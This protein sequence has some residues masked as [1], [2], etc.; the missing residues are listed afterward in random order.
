MSRAGFYEQIAANRQDSE[1]LQA[2]IRRT[3]DHFRGD[4]TSPSRPGVLLGKVQSGKTRAFLGIIALA[5]DEGYDAAVILT[6][7]T[8]SLAR[9]TIQRVKADFASFIADD[10]VQ[11]Y[12]I[13][14]LVELTGYELSQK[15]IFV[16]KK[17][18]DNMGRLLAAFDKPE[19]RSKRLL[20][21][22]DEADFASVT[23]RQ[24]G[25]VPGPGV[26]ASRIDKLQKTVADS[27][28]LQVTATPYSL[29]L[30]P[31][32]SA[33]RHGESLFLPKKPSFTEI[34]PIHSG[35]VGG[36]AYF[37]NSSDPGSTAHY[38]YREVPMQER[39]ALKKPDGRR[40]RLDQVLTHNNAAVLRQA[41]MT[42]LVGGVIRRIQ[43]SQARQAP[44]KFSF[45]FHT[46]Q[47]RASLDWQEQ[48]VTAIIDGFVK[49]AA[50]DTVVFRSLLNAAYDDLKPSLQVDD[51]AQPDQAEVAVEVKN[52]LTKGYVMITKVNS[53]QQVDQLL[54]EEG[55]LKLRTPFNLFI[56]GQILDRGVTIR[57][58]I[59]F[60][61]GRNPKRLQQDT[62]LQHSRM[63]GARPRGDL[64]V[65][66]FYAPKSIY[67]LMKRI[68]EFDSALRDAFNSG[69][70]DKGVYFIRNDNGGRLIPCSPNKLIFSD[71]TSIRPGK[72]LL[73]F[74]FQTIAKSYGQAPLAKLDAAI[75]ELC[76]TTDGVEALV[77]IEKAVAIVTHC[78]ELLEAETLDEDDRRAQI[79]ALEH[80]A[81]IAKNPAE[82]DKV[83][84]LAWRHRTLARER[85]SGRL[86]DSPDTKQQTDVAHTVATDAP[87][88]ILLRNNGHETDGWR[89]LPFWWPVVVVP[90][91]AV[92]SI[93]AGTEP[94]TV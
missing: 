70:H 31:E 87:A 43:Q 39:D 89:G 65:T 51:A 9:Q 91:N 26:I 84:I 83:H 4:K 21:I 80:L 6:K 40:L 45:L 42:F 68:H 66:R 30:Q 22:D 67:D 7:G 75:D 32:E 63:Y 64:P 74:G 90:R 14:Q 36:E 38:F 44:Q 88:L 25:G 71:L 15:L 77:P 20:I 29:Y 48:V 79:A 27:D 72:R 18:D 33:M 76:G 2:C 78:Y 35:Y 82:K 17:E 93:F 8:R 24:S 1:D 92:T 12:D 5:F 28:F 53:N 59:G 16:V 3:V 61:Y 54:D 57:N 50:D 94:A 56:G 69:A 81:K 62:V 41:L 37:E 58:M 10:Q 47:Q 11:V 73:P 49:G 60:Y 46:E 85:G 19:L 52:A 86:N 23:F 55:Q 34:L 13:M